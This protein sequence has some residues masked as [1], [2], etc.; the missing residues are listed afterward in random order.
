[1]LTA[2]PAG[3]VAG[4]DGLKAVGV[5]SAMIAPLAVLVGVSMLDWLMPLSEFPSYVEQE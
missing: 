1:L 5:G 2:F 4:A 3:A